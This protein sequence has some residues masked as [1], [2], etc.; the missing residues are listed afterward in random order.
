M[1]KL[2]VDRNVHFMLNVAVSNIEET[3]SLSAWT[4]LSSRVG[5]TIY[6]KKF[7]KNSDNIY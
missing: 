4:I 6:I 3:M 1:K 7:S 2:Y 5:Y